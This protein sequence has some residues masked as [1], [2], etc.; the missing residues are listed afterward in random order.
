MD[1]LTVLAIIIST[2]IGLYDL[3]L[4][5]IS[6]S[7]LAATSRD[8][9][10]LPEDKL[11]DVMQFRAFLRSILMHAAVGTTL[12]GICTIVGEP[13]NLIV[14][15]VASWQF[16]DYFIRMSVVS[17]PIVFFGLATCFVVEKFKL[18]GYGASMPDS[19]YQILKI[20]D[21]NN[22][23]SRRDKLNLLV[24]GMCFIWLIIALA[25]HLASV[26]LIGLS[27]IVL[28]A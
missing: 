3:Y 22:S 7:E 4:R 14:G 10:L 24:Q 8:D 17:L 25:F 2:A 16:G 23:L 19:V 26:G 21:R 11:H 1:A 6:G 15:S 18:F 5:T 27:V 9:A 28:Y 13:Q 12:G 20:Q